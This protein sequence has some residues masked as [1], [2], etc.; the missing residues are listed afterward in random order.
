VPDSELE[1]VREQLSAGCQ[2]LLGAIEGLSD[3]QAAFKPSPQASCIVECLEHVAVSERLM[4]TMIEHAGA[5]EGQPPAS[6]DRDR[7]FVSRA[8]DRARKFSAPDSTIPKSR[9]PA[10]EDA[11]REFL[12]NRERTLAFVGRSPGDVR[13]RRLVHPFAGPMDAYHCLLLIASRPSRHAAQIREIRSGARSPA[14]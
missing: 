12:E 2:A 1:L 7:S 14:S 5:A 13:A 10:H 6:L 9:F 11:R 8:V 3:A 4:L